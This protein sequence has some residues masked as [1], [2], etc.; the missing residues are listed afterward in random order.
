MG[1]NDFIEQFESKNFD[2][3]SEI[4]NTSFD[5]FKILFMNENIPL[6]LLRENIGKYLMNIYI[7]NR[8]ST[9][10]HLTIQ[11]NDKDKIHFM[12]HTDKIDE[13]LLK[14]FITTLSMPLVEST[15][16]S[17]INPDTLSYF[18]WE[19][20]R[21]VAKPSHIYDGD[22]FTSTWY[23]NNELV[24]YK[25][26]CLGYDSSEMRPRLNNP[27]RDEIKIKARQ[28]KER[29]IELL[30]QDSTIYIECGEFDKYGRLLVTIYNDT[31]GTKS[32]ND[33]MIEEGHGYEYYGGT[34][35]STV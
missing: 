21:F 13:T 25:C 2:N 32:L 26:R 1:L 33:I 35:Q 10:N 4:F 27:N 31:N 6:I 18:S 24:K 28:D 29:F 19:G 12:S 14:Q 17:D 34:K 3:L 5:D 30:T 20:Q 8:I 9:H 16:I 11:Q 22:T 15:K 23:Y 7:N